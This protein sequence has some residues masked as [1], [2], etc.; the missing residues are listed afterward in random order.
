M[1]DISQSGI[2]VQE[3]LL[4]L[5]KIEKEGSQTKGSNSYTINELAEK[6]S[7][8]YGRANKLVRLCVSKGFVELTHKITRKITG[9]T[10]TVPAVRFL[11]DKI[12]KPGRKNRRK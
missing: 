7:I 2:S 12:R 10:I 4:E 6:L 5:E 1:S 9:G 11:M 8:S 3:W